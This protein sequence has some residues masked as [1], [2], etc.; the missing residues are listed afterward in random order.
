M[1]HW[2]SDEDE[3]VFVLAGEVTVIEGT[4]E[5]ILRP[6]DAATFKAGEPVGHYLSNNSNAPTS[7]HVVGTRAQT[8]RITYPDHD[9]QLH[10]DRCQPEDAWTDMRGN[11]ARNPYPA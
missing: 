10:R 2:H 1:K 5:S 9:R 8:D 3:L 4:T 11:P 6:G 7:V